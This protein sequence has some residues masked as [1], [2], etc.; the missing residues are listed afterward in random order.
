MRC[1]F[2]ALLA[3]ALASCQ[4]VHFYSQAVRGQLEI[5]AK[6][7]PISE[8]IAVDTVSQELKRKLKLVEELRAFAKK[9]LRLPVKD[10]YSTYADLQR[11]FVVWVV[12]AAPEFSV[13][14]K[15][16]WYP[17]IGSQEYRGY[18]SMEDAKAEV[19]K[20]QAKGYDVFGGG[21]EA[22]STL[23]VF[24]DP[25]L[26][27]FVNR[28]DVKLAEL[29]FHELSHPRVFFSGDTDFNEAFATANSQEAV[30]RWLKSKHQSKALAEYDEE[31]NHDVEFSDL[32]LSTRKKLK[33]LYAQKSFSVEELRLKKQQIFA[34]MRKDYEF[35]KRTWHGDTTHDVWFTKPINNGRLNAVASYYDLVPG[36]T[37]LLDQC[38]GNLEIFYKAAESFKGLSK[39]E[40]R[41][42]LPQ[43]RSGWGS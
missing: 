3:S 36:F 25:I 22:Y 5:Q 39:E 9:E 29:I 2:Y 17:F 23:G 38:G 42:K 40:R 41:K 20:L 15:T 14:G 31:L 27:T 12:F 8:V 16:W 37:S 34:D 33:A 35:L 24:C 30:H 11:P 19:Q 28:S 13:E 18:F 7:K 6:A 43:C 4:T 32:V 21:V 10:Q 1:L 26:N